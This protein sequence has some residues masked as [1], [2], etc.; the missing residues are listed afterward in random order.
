MPMSSDEIGPSTDPHL[1]KRAWTFIQGLAIEEDIERHSLEDLP[2]F[3]HIA[4]AQLV[5]TGLRHQDG[6][7]RRAASWVAGAA[8]ILSDETVPLLVGLLRDPDPLVRMAAA[9]A[10]GDIGEDA[11]PAIP[12]LSIALDDES[13]GVQFAAV[14]A[15]QKF[16]TAAESA[17]DALSVVV[18]SEAPDHIRGKAL[19]A[20]ADISPG[21]P[22]VVDLVGSELTS[23]SQD[24]RFWAA[25][26][27]AKIEACS[28]DLVRRLAT[29]LD[30]EDPYVALLSVWALGRMSSRSRSALPVLLH[31]LTKLR[32]LRI[33]HSELP[34]EE[35]VDLRSD[36]GETL[37]RSLPAEE[38]PDYEDFRLRFFM[39]VFHPSPMAETRW[40][41]DLANHP[42]YLKI[43]RRQFGKPTSKAELLRIQSSLIE[44]QAKFRVRLWKQ[45][46]LGVVPEKC[47]SLP[48]YIKQHTRSIASHVR[49]QDKSPLLLMDSDLLD[50]VP[51]PR[52]KDVA[53]TY[54]REFIETRLSASERD[55]ARY[56]WLLG[57]T[58]EE[59]AAELQLTFSQVKYRHKKAMRK[60]Q[61]YSGEDS[62]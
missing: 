44:A 26:G 61:A 41:D 18:R 60:A 7:I 39:H 32:W 9:W 14:C 58:I 22:G 1:L 59:T 50:L 30:P 48:G 3:F 33:E 20:L 4:L 29:Q 42:W 28:E 55:V 16:G 24:L 38:D 49:K 15:L 21:H 5:P 10:C 35:F 25:Y 57:F 36:F 52:S 34:G 56:H 43:Q 31:A 19:A 37:E 12:G 23:P 13:N 40:I 51:G 54:L 46:T 6:G 17:V 47:L 45:P 11:L 62:R 2:E 8:D 53:Q 27:A